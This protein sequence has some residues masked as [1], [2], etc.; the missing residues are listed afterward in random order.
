MAQTFM[1][2]LIKPSRYDDDGYVLQ[3]CRSVYC[4]NALTVLNALVEDCAEKQVLGSGVKIIV[5]AYDDQCVMPPAEQLAKRMQSAGAGSLAC[6]V[7]SHTSQFPRASDLARR[8]R[9]C[10]IPVAMGGFHVSGTIAM[11]PEL[12][13][14][15]QAMLDIGV[16]LFAGEAEGRFKTLLQD[17]RAGTLKPVYNY[18]DDLIDITQAPPPD[19]I[20]EK[21]E[22]YLALSLDPI[23]FIEAGRGC[24]FNC[25]FCTVINV[26]GRRPRSRSGD[27]IVNWVRHKVKAG[28]VR[29][30]FTDD[31]LARNRN[32]REILGGLA[33]LR[34]E[35]GLKFSMAL[36]VDTQSDHDPDFIPLAVRA[37]TE[38]VFVG[39]ESINPGTL[40][41]V[42]KTQNVVDHYQQFFLKWKQHGVVTMSGY[43]IGF[44]DDTPESVRQDLKTIQENLPV[45]VIYPFILTPLPGSADHAALWQEG[46]PLDPNLSRYT[47][48]HATMPHPHMSGPEL[49]ALFGQVWKLFYSDRHTTRIMRRHV[50]LGGDLAPLVPFL[51]AARAAFSVE[52]IHPFEMGLIRVKNRTERHPALPREAAVPFYLRRG[53]GTVVSQLRWGWHFL[54]MAWLARRVRRTQG[55]SPDPADAALAGH[56][57]D[58]I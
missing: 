44:P 57:G 5:E 11:L 32:W 21:V 51:L 17:A 55:L 58:K 8:F 37:G 48:C 29:F 12:P 2:I 42:G 27:A 31:N 22:R 45:D 23:D 15:L 41:K 30:F 20:P 24:P 46:V 49:E 39:M 19:H 25:S 14:D 6:I 47:S 36:S 33:R 34:E 54:R 53:A 50:S 1:V 38:Q 16:S 52:K 43:I 40:A 56:D 35:E 10:G 9:A 26:H 18:L 3:W 4:S 13:P 7:G 28:R